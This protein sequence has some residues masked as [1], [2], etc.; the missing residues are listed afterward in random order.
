M[1]ETLIKR[2]IGA[3]AG[4][5]CAILILFIGFWRTVLIALLASA[6]WWLAG[7]RKIPDEVIEFFARITSRMRDK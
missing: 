5:L 2:L 7:S 1:S 4:V 3:G 6:G